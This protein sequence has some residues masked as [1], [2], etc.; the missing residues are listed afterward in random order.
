M[1]DHQ[2]AIVAFSQ[3]LDTQTP[4]P[5]TQKVRRMAKA[6]RSDADA[7]QVAEARARRFLSRAR[8]APAFPIVCGS[9]VALGAG[10]AAA[11]GDR[12]SANPS[13]NAAGRAVDRRGLPGSTDRHVET[14]AVRG[15]RHPTA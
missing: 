11:E 5:P 12:L 2:R 6:M 4:A 8:R 9:P 3:Y 13:T 10:G 14:A 7:R 1:T 15:Q